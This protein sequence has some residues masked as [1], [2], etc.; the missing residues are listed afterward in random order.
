[1]GTCTMRIYNSQVYIYSTQIEL[2]YV[3]PNTHNV[4]IEDSSLST[5]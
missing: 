1:M 4:Q 3:N 5:A 2:T